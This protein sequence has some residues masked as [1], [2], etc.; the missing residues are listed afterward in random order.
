M[1][2]FGGYMDVEANFESPA[3][4]PGR[5]RGRRGRSASPRRGPPAWNSNVQPDV[6]VRVGDR[7]D[8]R[9]SAVLR[10]LEESH[11]FVQKSAEST[12]M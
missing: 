3:S 2:I 11:R 6:N 7:F 10:E 1:W 9:L 8:A 12:S 4:R 5:R